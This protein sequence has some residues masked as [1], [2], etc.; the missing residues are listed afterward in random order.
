MEEQHHV[1]DDQTLD[2]G[3]AAFVLLFLPWT[4]RSEDARATYIYKGAQILIE[5]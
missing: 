1:H 5:H 4:Y 3:F 2:F